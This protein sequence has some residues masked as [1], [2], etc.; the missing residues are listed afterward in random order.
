MLLDRRSNLEQPDHSNRER[1]PPTHKS[2]GAWT[3]PSSSGRLPAA[4]VVLNPAVASPS[5]DYT[6]AV[7]I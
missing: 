1:A 5:R 6:Q 3:W 7:K 4:G 2:S